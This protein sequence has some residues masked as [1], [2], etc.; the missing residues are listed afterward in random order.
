QTAQAAR[1]AIAVLTLG[2]KANRVVDD[3]SAVDLIAPVAE[4]LGPDRALYILSTMAEVERNVQLARD[5]RILLELAFLKLARLQDLVPLTE[6]IRRLEGIEA[7]L[8][9]GG[10]SGAPAASAPP[11]QTPPRQAP[12]HQAPSPQSRPS[13]AR[14]QAGSPQPARPQS[15][16]PQQAPPRKAP[17]HQ[18]PPRPAA[19]APRSSG[20]RGPAPT[21]ASCK[22]ALERVA[23]GFDKDRAVLARG[24][25][26]A[27]VEGPKDGVLTLVFANG[28]EQGCVFGDKA[29]EVEIGRALANELGGHA[30]QLRGRVDKGAA[31]KKRTRRD[32]L[33]D[34]EVQTVLRHVQGGALLDFE[35]RSAS[36]E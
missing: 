27:R 5:D 26:S 31:G 3:P 7:R 32:V 21:T 35:E 9:A 28:F 4:L 13:Q 1:D 6:A 33:E 14:P 20:P 16:G 18:A 19:G 10:F 25:R 24:L 22:R 15:S 36:D 30:L 12:A 8:S 29:V 23:A 17:R 2:S 34:P 11:R